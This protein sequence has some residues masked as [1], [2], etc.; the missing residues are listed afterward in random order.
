MSYLLS[1]RASSALGPYEIESLFTFASKDLRQFL[2]RITAES[3]DKILLN[4]LYHTIQIKIHRSQVNSP[5]PEYCKKIEE[6]IIEKLFTHTPNSKLSD[7]K[8]ISINL[9]NFFNGENNLTF[10][11]FEHA[12]NEI[13]EL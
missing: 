6:A 7:I 8:N 3:S 11:E 13:I 12:A 10:D 1:E 2:S 4:I 5:Y 9:L